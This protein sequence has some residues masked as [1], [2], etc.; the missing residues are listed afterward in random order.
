MFEGLVEYSKRIN[1]LYDDDERH[2]LVFAKL[3]GA[4]AK[5]YELKGATNHLHEKSPHVCAQTCGDCM[6]SPLRASCDVRI[7]CNE[8]NGHF[9]S[10]T[11]YDN[12]KQRTMNKKSVCERKW[13]CAMCGWLVTLR[14]HECNKRFCENFKENRNVGHLCYMRPLKNALPS[15]VDKVLYVFYDFE[16][17]QNTGTRTRLNYTYV[18][19]SACKNSVLVAR[20]W[21]TETACFTVG[22]SIRSGNI[23]SGTCIHI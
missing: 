7:P 11:W 3:T 2:Y 13:C 8:S 15:T 21:K 9:R 1:L 6:A 20:T 22:G 19:P 14:N 4:K 18:F 16:T 23:Q 10:S 17:S 5:K 12:H